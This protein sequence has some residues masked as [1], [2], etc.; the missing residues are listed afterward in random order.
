MTSTRTRRIVRRL[1]ATVAIGLVV[2]SACQPAPPS[3]RSTPTRRVLLLGDS[4]TWGLFGTTPGVQPELV[5]QLQRRRIRLTVIGGPAS[6]PITP[7][8][9]ATPWEQDLFRV[10]A[11]E[12]PDIVIIQTMLLPNAEDPAVQVQYREAVRRLYDIAQSRGARTFR[13]IHT[14]SPDP[15]SA[16][17][18][19]IAQAIQE[20][21]GANRGI[22][23]IPLNTALERCVDPFV[24]D[25]FHVSGS[26]QRCHAAAVVAAIDSVR[27]R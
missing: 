18:T 24:S 15:A 22:G 23:V 16:A 5:P 11:T 13:V 9:N 19:A 27:R 20:D 26:G 17:T 8:L 2:L 7:W 6:T 1:T 14:A 10:V 3:G 21:E 4:I 12:N 25:G